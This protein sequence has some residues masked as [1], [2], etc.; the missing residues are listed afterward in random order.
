MTTKLIAL[1]QGDPANSDGT[2]IAVAVNGLIDREVQTKIDML[3]VPAVVDDL[4]YCSDLDHRFIV[5][6]TSSIIST[7]V[8]YVM[9]SDALLSVKVLQG[10]AISATS[11]GLSSAE[12]LRVKL[13]GITNPTNT[14]FANEDRVNDKLS[15]VGVLN[16]ANFAGQDLGS[17][18]PIGFVVHHYTDGTL[19][20]I[21][22][23]GESNVILKLKNAQNSNRRPDKAASF[24]GSGSFVQL[25]YHDDTAGFTKTGFLITEDFDFIWTGEKGNAAKIIQNKADNGLTAFRMEATTAHVN[26][27]DFVN[28]PNALITLR[29]DVALT[30]AVLKSHSSQTS[31]MMLETSSGALT[32]NP[33][34][35]LLTTSAL[36]AT[37]GNTILGVKSAGASVETQ[38]P[39]IQRGYAF[40]SLPVAATY[41]GS[42]I[43]V[44]D[45][46]YKRAYSDGTNWLFMSNDAVVT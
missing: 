8:S 28:G 15:P 40:A 17:S 44:T 14:L 35:D 32:L 13:A 24:V 41:T 27:F 45:R 26:V 30:R 2:D 1:A 18:A 31:G 9:T 29:N 12:D 34:G 7:D 42:E 37:S 21:D 20:Q 11:A 4:I 33:A 23:V 10:P 43:H 46:G 5:V 36:K 25:V 39:F 16:Y 38:V 19:M 22:N 6:L 3:A